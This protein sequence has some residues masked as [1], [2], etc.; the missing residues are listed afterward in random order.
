MIALLQHQ[1]SVGLH[2]QTLAQAQQLGGSHMMLPSPWSCGSQ[3]HILEEMS[4]D[5]FIY[6]QCISLK[7]TVPVLKVEG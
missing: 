6:D 4:R 2:P 3:C 5:E 7:H 1:L